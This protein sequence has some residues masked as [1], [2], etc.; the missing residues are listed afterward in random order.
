M[1]NVNISE[2]YSIKLCFSNLLAENLM[3]NIS[4]SPHFYLA[5]PPHTHYPYLSSPRQLE[6]ELQLQE[7]ATWTGVRGEGKEE[8]P[9][10]RLGDALF[11]PVF[12]VS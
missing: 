4:G 3:F 10:A 8:E 1:K 9:G 2:K 7:G 12:S 6:A 5:P 11:P